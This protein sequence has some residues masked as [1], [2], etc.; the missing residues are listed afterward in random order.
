MKVLS[1]P[2]YVFVCFDIF[3]KKNGWPHHYEYIQKPCP[4]STG[5]C[6]LPI[7]CCFFF[8]YDAFSVEH[9]AKY[10]NNK[11]IAHFAW[12]ILAAWELLCFNMQFMIVFL[13]LWW[14]WKVFQSSSV[15][16]ILLQY[17]ELFVYMSFTSLLQFTPRFL[18]LC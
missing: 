14:T 6:F 17:F 4:C 5:M 18:K 7:T 16:R 15:F 13:F 2:M 12:N 3:A 1:S 11:S 8:F 9:G 10:C